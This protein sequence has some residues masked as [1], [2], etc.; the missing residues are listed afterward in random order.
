MVKLSLIRKGLADNPG[1]RVV[2]AG[3]LRDLNV[4]DAEV[5]AYIAAHRERLYAHLSED[6]AK[7]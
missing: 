3:T 5:D 4:T 7:G 6:T 1:F 2:Y